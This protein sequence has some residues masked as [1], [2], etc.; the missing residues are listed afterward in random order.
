MFKKYPIWFFLIIAIG[1]IGDQVSKN[2]A[3]AKLENGARFF[4]ETRLGFELA[5]NSGSAFSLFEN[6]TLI[7]AIL[8][9]VIAICLIVYFPKCQS[10]MLQIGINLIIAGAFGNLLD[11]FVR[12]PYYGKGHVVDFIVLWNW[13]NFN[14]ADSL[15]CVGVV[16]GIIASFRIS[17]SHHSKD[18][19]DAVA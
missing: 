15:I 11:R 2:I 7:L 9:F 5:Y 13:P 10:R 17:N 4:G 3:L 18:P 1:V 14:I 6:S 8:A 16:I 19:S 12:T